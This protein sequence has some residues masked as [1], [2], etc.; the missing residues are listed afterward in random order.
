MKWVVVVA[1][2]HNG[3][4]AYIVT[5]GKVPARDFMGIF[6]HARA[7]LFARKLNRHRVPTAADAAVERMRYDRAMAELGL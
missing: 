5:D 2:R 3:N 6:A 4:A 1:R 7:R